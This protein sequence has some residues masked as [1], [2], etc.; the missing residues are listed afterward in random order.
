MKNSILGFILG[1]FAVISIAAGTSSTELLT[2]KPAIPK[3]TVSFSGF[4]SDPEPIINK[5]KIYSSKGYILKE[6]VGSDYT[7]IIVMEKY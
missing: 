6:M 7:Y 2:I 1:V 3:S 4:R 5:I